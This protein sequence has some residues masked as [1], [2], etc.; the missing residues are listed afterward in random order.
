MLDIN[1]L[2]EEGKRIQ[3]V[4]N[5]WFFYSDLYKNS[6]VFTKYHDNQTNH[7][8]YSCKYTSN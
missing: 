3:T 5:W 6:Q 8:I 2:F 7:N 4:S 1:M